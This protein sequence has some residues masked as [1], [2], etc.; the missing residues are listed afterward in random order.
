M[1]LIYVSYQPHWHR[2]INLLS[3]FSLC[4]KIW[5]NSEGNSSY[6]K[7]TFTLQ[8]RTFRIMAGAKTII[9]VEVSLRD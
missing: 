2:Q 9:H 1:K 6:S 4:N 8:K 5:N 3:L 7:M